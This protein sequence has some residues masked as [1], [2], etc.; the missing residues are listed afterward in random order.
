MEPV[1]LLDL[2]LQYAALREE[3]DRAVAGV[4]ASQAFV[5]GPAVERFER[6]LAGFVGCDHA[7]G[8]ASGTDALWAVPRP[9][10]QDGGA[11]DDMS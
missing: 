9:M 3:I 10:A 2:K 4:V 6:A 11:R 1:P 5:L 8:C 7:I